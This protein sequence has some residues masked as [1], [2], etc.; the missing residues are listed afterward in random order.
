[1]ELLCGH[2]Q[3]AGDGIM[4]ATMAMGMGVGQRR[5]AACHG[6]GGAHWRAGGPDIAGLATRGGSKD[7]FIYMANAR[8]GIAI[9][10]GRCSSSTVVCS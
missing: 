1:V 6:G 2:E 9:D 4:G 8:L 10:G 7:L 5:G 3:D